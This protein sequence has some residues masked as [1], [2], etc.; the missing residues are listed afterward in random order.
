MNGAQ[1]LQAIQVIEP[2]VVIPIH[3]ND[4]AVFKSPLEHFKQAARRAGIESRVQYLT[5]GETY[6]FEIS[7]GRIKP[8]EVA[9]VA[10]GI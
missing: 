7:S 2:D 8:D 5:H 6:H 3:Y 9:N 10:S 1:G 4:Y